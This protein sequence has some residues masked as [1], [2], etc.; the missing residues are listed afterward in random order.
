MTVRVNKPAFNLREKL[1]ELERPI[2]IKGNEVLQSETV[3]DAF[4]VLGCGRKN[5]I[6]NGAME[7]WQRGTSFS[8]ISNGS[9]TAD[10]FLNQKTSTTNV[11]R[12]SVTEDSMNA[13]GFRYA[14]RQTAVSASTIKPL[15]IIEKH[16][17]FVK[18]NKFTFSFWARA[19]KARNY[20]FSHYDGSSSF[21]GVT[22]IKI[23]TSWK[24]FVIPLTL[25]SDPSSY[26]RLH[27]TSSGDAGD[28]L[29][30]TGWQYEQGS[31]ATP[32]EHR[33]YG[34]EFALCERYYERHN[35]SAS[36]YMAVV[37][38]YATGTQMRTTLPFLTRKRT[39]SPT[40]TYSGSYLVYPPNEAATLT[41]SD[42][43][44]TCAR[45]NVTS[46]TSHAAGT[47]HLILSSGAGNYL[48]IED[49]L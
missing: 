42:N 46:A 41:G 14:M 22:G 36:Q 25:V 49:E 6:I 44:D 31:V 32:F 1:S 45:I 28:W 12:V 10:R 48:E 40:V 18:G 35:F 39:T 4:D 11:E 21:N 2:G 23:E 8:N 29:E 34:E 30:T 33:F 19:N 43:N 27:I 24:R 38:N 15:Q 16:P 5:F 26:L 3:E 9:Y 37:V 17:L 13:Y 47:A 20:S 7:I